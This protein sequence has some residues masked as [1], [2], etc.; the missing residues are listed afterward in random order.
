MKKAEFPNKLK[1]QVSKNESTVIK[2]VA[3]TF[4]HF[5]VD[6]TVTKRPGTSCQ[7]EIHCSVFNR[8]YL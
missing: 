4:Y 2:M 3:Y 5:K 8:L 1:R 6:L 7:K